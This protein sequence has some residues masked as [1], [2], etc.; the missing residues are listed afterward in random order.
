MPKRD[1]QTQAGARR[2]TGT[3]REARATRE[4][5]EAAVIR[6]SPVP[7]AHGAL[8]ETGLWSHWSDHLASHR[9]GLTDKAEYFAVRNSAGIFDFEPALQVPHRRARRR[10]V[11]RRR[12]RA[13]HPGV[14]AR[15]TPSTRAGSTTAASSS[16]TASSSDRARTSSCSRARSRTSPGCQTGSRRMTS[17]RGGQRRDLGTLALQGPRSRELVSRLVPDAATIPY[18]GLAHGK[19]GGSSVTVSRGR[20]SPATSATRSGSMPR[21]PCASGT[22]SGRACRATACSRSASMH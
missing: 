21:E 2:E 20:A 6:T 14:P 17:V 7:P 11:P 1:G 9:Y 4:A 3:A 13:R 10:G 15:A 16:R 18:F 22:R 8:N 12:A 19:I 5:G